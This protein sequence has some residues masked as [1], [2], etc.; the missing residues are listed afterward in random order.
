[1]LKDCE[2]LVAN[3]WTIFEYLQGE[4]I[5]GC[6][7]EQFTER[8]GVRIVFASGYSLCLASNGSFWIDDPRTT[9]LQL[10]KAKETLR[11]LMRRIKNIRMIQRSLDQ[12]ES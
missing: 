8:S 10:T 12:Q 9:K 4:K 11:D 1:M 3:D 6:V 5:I 7:R 2:H